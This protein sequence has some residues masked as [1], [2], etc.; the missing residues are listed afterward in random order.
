VVI[1]RSK[2]L[3]ETSV[4]RDGSAFLLKNGTAT[5]QN[6]AREQFSI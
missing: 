3:R 5:S 6:R 2:A 4:R 1:A